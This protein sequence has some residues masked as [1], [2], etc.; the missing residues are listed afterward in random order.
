MADLKVLDE[1]LH[2]L[3]NIMLEACKTIDESDLGIENYIPDSESGEMLK[4]CLN[5][6]D[7]YIAISDGDLDMK[8]IGLI[9]SIAETN[10]SKSEIQQIV[11]KAEIRKDDYAGQVPVILRAFVDADNEEDKSQ[12]GCPLSVTLYDLFATAGVYVMA[13][14]EKVSNE[15]YARLINYLKTMHKFIKQNLKF[16]YSDVKK[17]EDLVMGVLNSADIEVNKKALKSKTKDDETEQ[18][19]DEDETTL[20]ALLNELNSM[21]GLDEVKYEVTTLTNLLRI[22]AMREKMGLDMPPVSMH[23]VFSGNPGTGKTTVARL[24]AKIYKKI[25][26]LSKGQLVETDRSGLVGGYVGQTALKVSDVVNSAK[27]G[28]LFIDEAYSLTPENMTNDYGMEAVDT[29]VKAMEDNREDLIVIV[30]GYPDL[31]EHFLTSNPG[32]KSR[33][34]KFINFKDYTPDE[35]TQIFTTFCVQNGYRSS[36]PALEYVNEFF[37]DRCA[38]KEK[39]F[40]NAREVRNLFEYALSRQANRVILIN[41]PTQNDLTLLTRADVSGEN[42]DLG[43]QQYMAQ[44]VMNDLTRPK[45]HGILVDDAEMFMDELELSASTNEVLGK[46]QISTV[47]SFLDYLDSGKSIS[48]LNGISDEVVS[49]IIEGLKTIGFIE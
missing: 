19:E 33:F 36:K 11:D 34:N 7:I 40:A 18:P 30:A 39:N 26:V 4:L 31:M 22:K 35:L 1:K 25:G 16:G 44:M 32:L 42:I 5:L 3:L 14:N 29:L 38:E 21:V 41:N 45:R 43:K 15:E 46:N 6:F 2:G 23:L 17:P 28:V 37:A 47:K 20:E 27:G 49:E 10:F 9:N 8:E 48:D 12:G 24:L 13:V